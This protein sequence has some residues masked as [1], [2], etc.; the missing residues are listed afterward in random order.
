M[1]MKTPNPLSSRLMFAASLVLVTGYAV[2][3]AWTTLDPL[4][5]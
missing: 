3:Y 2:V 4:D 1:S 5:A